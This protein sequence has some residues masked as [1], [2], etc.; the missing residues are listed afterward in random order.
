MPVRIDLTTAVAKPLSTGSGRERV[1]L[2]G[3][4]LVALA[5]LIRTAWVCDDAYITLRVVDNLVHGYG[6]RWNVDERVAAFTHPLW[7]LLLSSVYVFTREAYF[8]SLAL[9]ILVTLMTMTGVAWRGQPSFAAGAVPLLAL[10]S[11]KAFVDFSTSGL[12]NPLTDFLL[13]LFVLAW[14][15]H[16]T[17]GRLSRLALVAG[18]VLMNRTDAGLLLAPALAVA[19][20]TDARQAR[21]SA[22]IGRLAAGMAPLAVWTTFAV[23]YFGSPIANTAYAKLSTGVPAASSIRQ[24]LYYFDLGFWFDPITLLVMALVPLSIAVKPARRDWPLVAGVVLSCLYVVRVGGDFMYGRFLVAPFFMSL[25][26]LQP[27]TA[28][29][30]LAGGIVTA[31]T[32]LTIG[33]TA[34]YQPSLLAGMRFGARDPANKNLAVHGIHDE[35][36]WYYPQTGLLRQEP[37]ALHPNHPW[38]YDGL[39]VRASDEPVVSRGNIGFYGYFAGPRVHVIDPYGLADPLLARLPAVPN[40]RIGH[41]RRL[42]PPGY[43]ESVRDQRVEI[44][45]P[46]LAEYYRRV[47]LITSGPL[48]SPARLQA[49]LDLNLGRLDYLVDDYAR[50]LSR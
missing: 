31:A 45:N 14:N 22:T 42:M 28:R 44:A 11:S 49:I 35:R 10:L 20:V 47:H 18:L 24:G 21:W 7:M 4:M 34:P 25:L 41:F 3:L 48:L 36:R 27:L 1:L 40:S 46:S 12:E 38:V 15:R 16:D 8:T 23:L 33:L 37:G 32:I 29:L 2:V 13:L 17:R 26:I 6:L 9:G 30:S 50:S 19:T 39:N 5:V 43:P